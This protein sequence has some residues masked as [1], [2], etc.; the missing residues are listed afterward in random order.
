MA[1]GIPHHLKEDPNIS[2]APNILGSLLAALEQLVTLPGSGVGAGRRK[3]SLKNCLITESP[4]NADAILGHGGRP[5]RGY[6]SFAGM[7]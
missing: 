7:P 3:R 6:F 2:P 4:T 5:V 1:A